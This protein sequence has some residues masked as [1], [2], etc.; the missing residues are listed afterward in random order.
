MPF[1]LFFW[2]HIYVNGHQPLSH[3]SCLRMRMKCNYQVEILHAF[4]D[5]FIF[6][7]VHITDRFIQLI[8]SHG[9]LTLKVYS[10]HLNKVTRSLHIMS[11]PIPLETYLHLLPCAAACSGGLLE[12]ILNSARQLLLCQ[13][14]RLRVDII[15]TCSLAGEK[16]S[17]INTTYNRTP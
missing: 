2:S 12:E 1:K 13:G 10:N 4:Y 3:N 14:I 9:W 6:N 5:P 7:V 15:T 11:Q 8:N 17:R 16:T